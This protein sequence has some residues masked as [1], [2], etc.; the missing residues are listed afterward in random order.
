MPD[1]GTEV[2]EMLP[3]R[4]SSLES[5][6]QDKQEEVGENAKK[7]KKADGIRVGPVIIRH[8]FASHK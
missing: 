3:P 5:G 6:R 4:S 7:E 1:K 8:C 2:D